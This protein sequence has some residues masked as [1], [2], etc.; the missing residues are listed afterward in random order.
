MSLKMQSGRM[1]WTKKVEKFVRRAKADWTCRKTAE[2]IRFFNLYQSAY[3]I[4]YDKS[5]DW[6]YW[7]CKWWRSK[8]WRSFRGRWGRRTWEYPSNFRKPISPYCLP[9]H[10]CLLPPPLY[11]PYCVP[12]TSLPYCPPPTVPPPP[13]VKKK[14]LD[15]CHIPTQIC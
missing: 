5:E 12:P 13:T 10:Y 1:E 15:N 2:E 6:W 8:W 14:W 4:T 9:R 11:C 3:I 7:R